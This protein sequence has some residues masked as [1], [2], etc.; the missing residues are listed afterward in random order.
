MEN[1]IVPN[2]C[3]GCGKC[4]IWTAKKSIPVATLCKQCPTNLT[5]Y[6]GRCEHL[7]EDNKCKI[8]NQQRPAACDNM[9][10]GSDG[11]LEAIKLNS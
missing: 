5:F 1:F 9:V 7:T 2:D 4:C 3:K 11:C 10:K 8:Y 6:Y